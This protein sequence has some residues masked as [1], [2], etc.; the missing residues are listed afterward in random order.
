MTVPVKASV[1]NNL[2][3]EINVRLRAGLPVQPSD[4]FWLNRVKQDAKRLMKINAVE[5]Y[6][7]LAAIASLEWDEKTAR[8]YLTSATNLQPGVLVK[9]QE[10]VLLTNFG[11]FLEAFRLVNETLSPELGMF[12]K[13][14][15]V[16]IMIG[17]FQ[18]LEKFQQQAMSMNGPYWSTYRTCI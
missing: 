8:S 11:Y 2:I 13:F 3:D 14:F 18:Q 9:S 12:Q 7:V 16:F 4:V 6:V 5:A 10:I 15:N 17:A 1:Y